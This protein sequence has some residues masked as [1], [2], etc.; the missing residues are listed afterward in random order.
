MRHQLEVCLDGNDILDAKGYYATL[1]DIL[2][3]HLEG[4]HLGVDKDD[5][6]ASLPGLTEMRTASK[7]TTWMGSMTA[8]G[9]I[10]DWRIT[11][12]A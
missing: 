2:K 12:I 4:H 3:A 8:S 10:T 7:G 6:F 5:I 1:K 11:V 9:F